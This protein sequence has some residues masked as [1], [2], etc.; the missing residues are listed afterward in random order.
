MY[1]TVFRSSSTCPDEIIILSLLCDLN[2][3]S[4]RPG[5]FDF[6]FAFFYLLILKR[7]VEK[8]AVVV[9]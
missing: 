7:I 3:N 8:V 4:Q 6:S 2:A 1:F 5:R 9:V